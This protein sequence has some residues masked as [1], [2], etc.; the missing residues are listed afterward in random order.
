MGMRGYQDFKAWQLAHEWNAKVFDMTAK[1][2]AC[3]DFKFRDNI[4]D[5]ADS[6]ERKLS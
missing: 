4:R 1:A 6:A 2:P 3:Y 5:A